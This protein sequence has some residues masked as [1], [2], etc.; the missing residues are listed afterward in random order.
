[1]TTTSQ[2]ILDVALGLPEPE[3][4]FIVQ[5]LLDSLSLNTADDQEEISTAELDRRLAKFEQGQAGELSWT[6]L[7]RQ[8]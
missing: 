5:G 6:E 8:R 1:M 3:R 2:G 4:V 7:K